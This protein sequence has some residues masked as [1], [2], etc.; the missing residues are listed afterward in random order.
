MEEQQ[1]T[2]I[3]KYT[4]ECIRVVR[5][6]TI[7]ELNQKITFAEAAYVNTKKTDTSTKSSLLEHILKQLDKHKN[8]LALLIVR[9]AGKPLFYAQNEI[10]R[11]IHTVQAGIDALNAMDTETL[12]INLSQTPHQNASVRRFPIGPIIGIAP[13]NFPLNL[14]LHKIIPAICTGNTLL[15]KP[16]P[17]APLTL[18]FF[19]NTLL[20]PILPIQNWIQIVH[21]SDKDAALLVKDTRF[22]M[23][24]FTGSAS[25]GW[26]IKENCGKKKIALELG[27]NAPVYIHADAAIASVAEKCAFGAFLYAGQICISTQR[28]YVHAT[29]FEEF[30]EALVAAAQTC[31]SGNPFNNVLNGPII[32]KLHTQRIHSWVMEAKT[33]GASLLCGGYEMEHNIYAPTLLTGT[34]KGMKVRDEEIF[35]PVAIVEKVASIEEAIFQIN[36]SRYG[37]QCGIYSQDET[38]IQKLYTEIDCGGIIINNIPGFRVDDM[39][40]GGVKDSGFGREGI[41]YAI[42]ESTELKLLVR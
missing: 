6:D 41:R 35:G 40:Y 27:G 23:I 21:C 36:D 30:T 19:I 16:S 26:H 7:T 14:A 39:P 13:F 28:I 8:E 1:I 20:Q 42:E 2:I 15:I 33:Q 34:H 25:V 22:K 10:E 17:L 29:I 9:E 24:S 3:D 12:S 31:T 37:L 18:D 5:L 11:C 38:V 32:S 4:G